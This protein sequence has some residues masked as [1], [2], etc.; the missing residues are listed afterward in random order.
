MPPTPEPKVSELI[1][2]AIADA[3]RLALAQLA[4]AKKELTSSGESAGKGGIFGVVALL[5]VAQASF[6]MLFALVY[7]LVQL[8]LPP[9]ASFL[10]VA[11]LLLAGAAVAGLLARKYFERIKG[12]EVSVAELEKTREAILGPATSTPPTPTE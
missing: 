9:W 8:G 7:V 6:F 10:I 4:L 11:L 2:K 5:L 12:P 3:Q 1:G